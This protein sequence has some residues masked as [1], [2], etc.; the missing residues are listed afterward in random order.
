MH[1]LPVIM[2]TCDNCMFPVCGACVCMCVCVCV[3]EWESERE[4][5]KV[6]MFSCPPWRVCV[7]V[8]VCVR[9]C[10]LCVCVCQIQADRSLGS[11]QSQQQTRFT[12]FL[13]IPYSLSLQIHCRLHHQLKQIA[14]NS[15]DRH[16]YMHTHTHTQTRNHFLEDQSV[17]NINS[18]TVY[19]QSM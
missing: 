11:Q 8:C 5:V 16:T 10:V 9:V 14:S 12:H 7:C 17:T 2:R 4:K 19:S 13:I 3:S 1:V 15:P 6:W 18:I